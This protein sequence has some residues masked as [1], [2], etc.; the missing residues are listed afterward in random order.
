MNPVVI[1]GTDFTPAARHAADAASALARYMDCPLALVHA[2]AL[3]SYPPMLEQLSAEAVRLRQQGADVHESILEGNADEKLVEMAKPKSCRMVVVS[4]LGKRAPQRWLLGSV[5]ERTAERALVP[6]LVVRDAAPFLEWTCGERPL[7]VFVAFNF[8]ETSEAALRWIREFLLV[9]PCVVVVGYVDYPPEQRAR[10]GSTEPLALV[11]NPPEVQAILERDLKTRVTEILGT[12]DFQI[13][14]EANWGRPDAALAG[15]AKDV[16]ADLVVIGSHQYQGF[17][18]V[19]NVSIS[20]RLLHN[21]TMNVVVV[22]LATLKTKPVPMAPPVERVLVTTDFSVMANRAIPHAYSLLRGG[23][24]I[25]LVHV[26]HPHQ[27]P[28]GEYLQGRMDQR[29]KTRHAK[30]VRACHEKLTEMIPADAA[31]AGILTEVEVVEHRDPAQGICQA[32]ERFNA[33]AICLASHG[34]TGLASV[35]L[36]SVA[37]SLLGKSKRPLYLVRLIED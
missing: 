26:M 9:G 23:G 24:T 34:H 36:G 19:W 21:T 8:T 11:G 7:R 27:L 12:T 22:P 18:R 28:N 17:E 13:R 6:T 2:S 30:H 3:P 29:F 1:C 35:V 14:V 10:L 37:M 20:R 5:S 4:A 16:G 32:A 15:M 33:H 25:H 31:S